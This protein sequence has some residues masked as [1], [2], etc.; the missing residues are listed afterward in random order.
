MEQS[1]QVPERRV[2]DRRFSMQIGVR[3]Q[4][5]GQRPLDITWFNE[6]LPD[7]WVKQ[8][9]ARRWESFRDDIWI[10]VYLLLAAIV[11]VSIRTHQRSA[12]AITRF[13]VPSLAARYRWSRFHRVE[14]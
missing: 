13:H 6:L 12:S 1:V 5:Y 11:F 10:F 14:G 4:F 3:R 2:H 8:T 7:G 9:K